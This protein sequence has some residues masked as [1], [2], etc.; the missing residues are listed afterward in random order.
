MKPTIKMPLAILLLGTTIQSW[1]QN[2]P[3][4]AE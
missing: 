1:A 3:L 2:N 4:V